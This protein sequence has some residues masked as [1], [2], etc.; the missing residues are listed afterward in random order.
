MNKIKNRIFFK[1]K[2][3]HK[4]ELLSE[5]TM[6]LLESSKKDVDHNTDGEILPKLETVEVALVHCNLVNNNY[7]QLSKLLFTFVPNKQFGQLITIT[8]HSLTMLKT[9]N[10]EFPF[11]EIWFTDQNNR[12]LEIEDNVNITLIIGISYYKNEIFG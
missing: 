9:T 2:T 3:G 6:Q 8:P 12:P 7:Q 10:A 5:E 4:L 11:I 1:I